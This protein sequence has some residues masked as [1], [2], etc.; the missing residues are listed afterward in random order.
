MLPDV[1]ETLMDT[2]MIV[3]SE[4][5]Y[6]DF[7]A[8]TNVNKQR[9][10][11]AKEWLEFQDAQERMRLQ[12]HPVLFNDTKWGERRS[13]GE[14]DVIEN[15]PTSEMKGFLDEWYR[16]DLSAARRGGE[17]GRGGG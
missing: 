1:R 5:L 3:M 9:S 15:G 16:Q 17:R 13:I 4:W 7:C 8:D 11:I 12:W 14:I 10:I 2:A 6:A